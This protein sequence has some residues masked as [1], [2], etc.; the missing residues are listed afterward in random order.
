MMRYWEGERRDASKLNATEADPWINGYRG[1]Y[2]NVVPPEPVRVACRT[3]DKAREAF[4]RGFVAG[5]RSL[6]KIEG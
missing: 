6:E 4:E 5:R 3:K 1:G 2:G